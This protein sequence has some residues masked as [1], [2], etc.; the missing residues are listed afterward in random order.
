MKITKDFTG[1]NIR[2]EKQEGNTYF[3]NNEL[4]DTNEDWF[5][6]AFCAEGEPGETVV[7]KCP[8]VRIGYYGPAVSHD[9]KSWEWFGKSCDDANAFTYTFKENEG[10]V[11]FAHDMLY[12]PERFFSF[13]KTHGI[14][15]R[16][17]CKSRKG[18]SVPYF[19]LGNGE[20][21]VFITARH[22][23][24][25]AT[26]SYVL[27]GVLDELIN[28]PLDNIRIVCV[29]FVDYDGVLDGD[30][31][32]S[33]APHDH[34][35]D[36]EIGI[37][38]I[39]P[40]TAAIREL[41]AGGVEYAFDFHSP[42]HF[43]GEN[44]K[45]FIVR[46]LKEKTPEYDAFGTLFEKNITEDSMKYHVADDHPADYLWASSDNPNYI[47][48]MY[49]ACGAKFAATLE[50]AY[51]GTPDNIF[52]QSKGVE[53]GHCFVRALKQYDESFGR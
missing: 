39:Y 34:N 37:D 17:L 23:A 30:Q 4:R 48:F 52:T 12:H 7:C 9:L 43:S 20:R 8:N 22:H 16:E 44:D 15:L 36:Y 19:T 32:K 14:E 29:P 3:L 13:A 47:G 26:G 31:G 27:E 21:T 42:W 10:K 45:A 11:Y 1:A 51:F 46:K 2:I 49:K 28:N 50:T 6:W 53:L 35:R 33:R 40:E 41:A 24:C 18:R 38:A 5:Y 25:E